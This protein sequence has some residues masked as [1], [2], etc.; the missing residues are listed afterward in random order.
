MNPNKFYQRI[1]LFNDIIYEIFN[2]ESN[3]RTELSMLNLN[4]K[5]KCI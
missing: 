5:M 3:Y 2:T 4:I 1:K